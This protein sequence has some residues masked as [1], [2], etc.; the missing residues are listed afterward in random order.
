M[1]NDGSVGG[2]NRYLYQQTDALNKSNS[3]LASGKRINSAADDAAGLA[4]ADALQSDTV[5]LSQASRNIYDASSVNDIKDGAY[6]SLS[7]ISGRLSE[8]ATQSS[9]GTL[10]DQQRGTIN[11]EFQSLTQ[12]ANRIVAT[13]SFNGQNVFSGSTDV[14]VGTDS[15]QNSTI[16]LTDPGLGQTVSQLTPLSVDSQANAQAAL[17]QIQS[18]TQSLSDS[19]GNLGAQSSRLDYANSVVQSQKDTSTAAESRIRDVDYADEVSKRASLLISQQSSVALA[20]HANLNANVVA[21]L[22]Q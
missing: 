3:K 5:E 12:E 18:F 13:T 7:D 9:N 10:S 21:K 8:L 4:I 20:A 2:I 17:T 11:T 14:Q 15:S 16:T 6:S 1:A 22:L 19:R